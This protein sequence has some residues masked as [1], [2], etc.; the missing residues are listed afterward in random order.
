M[1]WE[2]GQEETVVQI[3]PHLRLTSPAVTVTVVVVGVP[4]VFFAWSL[5]RTFLLFSCQASNVLPQIADLMPS[6]GTFKLL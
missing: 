5:A 3:F 6:V 4:S 1:H 2:T